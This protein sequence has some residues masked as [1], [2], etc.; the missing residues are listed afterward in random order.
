MS[1]FSASKGAALALLVTSVVLAGCTSTPST[2]A[3]PA[4][5]AATGA[6]GPVVT[7]S[8]TT[9]IIRGVVVDSAIH[10]LAGAK[11]SLTLAGKSVSTNTTK[12]GAFGFQGLPPGT[13]IVTASKPGFASARSSWDVVAGD[14][15]PHILKIQLTPDPASAPYLGI[16]KF[17]GYIECSVTVVVVVVAACSLAGNATG[18]NFLASYNL[19][20]PPSL[21]QSEM[22]WSSTQPTGSDLDLS[23]TDFSQGSQVTVNRTHG[24]SPIFITVNQ[25]T[26]QKF[27]YGVNNSVVVRVFNAEYPPTDPGLAPTVQAAYSSTVYPAYN[28]TAPQPAKDGYATVVATCNTATK[29][30]AGENCYGPLDRAECVPYPTLFRACLGAGGVGATVEQSFTVYTDVFYHFLPPAGWRLSHDGDPPIPA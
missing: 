6:C 27:H 1:R 23:I 5:D 21:I 24:P 2:A 7:A 3:L 4:C 8:P 26:A 18:D 13:Y 15:N 29:L 30:A 14:Q 20:Q 16:Y 12:E 28:G 25:T 11:V 9:G 10:P 22:V 19:D 17:D